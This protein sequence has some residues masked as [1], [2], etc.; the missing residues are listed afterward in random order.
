MVQC[1]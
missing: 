1:D